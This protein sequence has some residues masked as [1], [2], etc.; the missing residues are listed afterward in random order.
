MEKYQKNLLREA[1]W[2]V[3][4]GKCG[5]CSKS[6]ELQDFDVEHIVPKDL[7]KLSSNDRNKKLK[8]HGLPESFDIDGLENFYLSCGGCNAKKSNRLLSPGSLA[9]H[10][11]VA[12]KN[13]ENILAEMKKIE[14]SK[15]GVDFF[16][17]LIS[18]SDRKNLSKDINLHFN[19]LEQSDGAF[20]LSSGLD[21]FGNESHEVLSRD[22]FEEYM[23]IKLNFPWLDDGLRLINDQDEEM[24]VTTLREYEVASS[25]GF[26][27]GSNYEMKTEE[28]CFRRPLE[29]LQ[30]LMKSKP[31]KRSFI[32]QP[33]KGLPD[34]ELLPVGLLW[35][36]G[37]EGE[38]LFDGAITIGELV[39]E[40]KARI[41]DIGT[42]FIRIEYNDDSTYL[43]EIMRTDIDGDGIEDILLHQGGGPLYGTL[44]TGSRMAITRRSEVEIFTIIEI[45]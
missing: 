34:I 16:F 28:Y 10:L 35:S 11:D 15:R 41:S 6:V 25:R 24:I 7:L 38:E 27:G 36:F 8:E 12:S 13:K 19:R 44:S 9:I 3:Y 4:K 32:N 31:P 2:N 45:P 1:I 20:R 40:G 33:R 37:V 22:Q 23:D 5:Y 14:S 17:K 29:V 26:Y 39:R 18:D 30:I 42:D 21:L 43:R